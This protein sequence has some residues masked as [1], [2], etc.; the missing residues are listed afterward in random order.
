MIIFLNALT[1]THSH[2]EGYRELRA[3]SLRLLGYSATD[4]AFLRLCCTVVIIVHLLSVYT[5]SVGSHLRPRS[6]VGY[7]YRGQR[8]PYEKEGRYLESP[9]CYAR[10]SVV[11]RP[12]LR[13]ETASL[14]AHKHFAPGSSFLEDTMGREQPCTRYDRLEPLPLLLVPFVLFIL[15]DFIFFFTVI[16]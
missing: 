1:R 4:R 16:L 12:V 3:V 15:P 5:V 10:S 13:Q 8:G 11:L 9:S 14:C 6:F 2:A 7:H